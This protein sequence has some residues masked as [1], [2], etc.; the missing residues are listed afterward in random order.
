MVYCLNILLIIIIGWIKFPFS[1]LNLMRLDYVFLGSVLFVRATHKHTY[2]KV[3]NKNHHINN[4][5][6]FNGKESVS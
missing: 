1:F 2:F 5:N 3:A 6:F 4:K